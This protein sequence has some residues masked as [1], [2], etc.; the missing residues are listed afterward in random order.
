M[1][2]TVALLSAAF[3]SSGAAP[4]TG[5][6]ETSFDYRSALTPNGIVAIDGRRVTDDAAFN[7]RVDANGLVTG[8]V[9]GTRVR[10]W[11]SAAAARR[12]SG[13]LADGSRLAA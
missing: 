10:F 8:K 3:V 13:R 12:L 4:A 2:P 11:V 1:Y 7:L 5:Q 6:D 9:G